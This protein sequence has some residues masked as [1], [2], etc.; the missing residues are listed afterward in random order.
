MV[1]LMYPALAF[2]QQQSEF[3]QVPKTVLCGPIEKI[4]QALSHKEIDEKPFWIGKNEDGKSNIAVFVNSK[5]SSFT[6]VQFVREI[7]CI[8]GM[9]ES[10]Q[11][12]DFT[13][14]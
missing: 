14:S 10:S 11:R 8:L 2:S 6:I 1:F 9:G 5:T 3:V 4:L 13:K 7:G 12:L